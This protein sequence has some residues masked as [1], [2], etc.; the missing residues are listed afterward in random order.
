MGEWLGRYVNGWID[1]WVDRALL[2]HTGFGRSSLLM[3]LHK[4]Q[5]SSVVL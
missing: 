1:E 5:N 2:S 3:E 4:S